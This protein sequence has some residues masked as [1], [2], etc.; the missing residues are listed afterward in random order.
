MTVHKKNAIEIN[1]TFSKLTKKPAK[2]MH[3][4]IF[5]SESNE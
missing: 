4:L 3:A 1:I 2:D 5:Y